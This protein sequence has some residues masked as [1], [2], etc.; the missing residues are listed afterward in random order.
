[1]TTALIDQSQGVEVDLHI[2]QGADW[3]GLAFPILDALNSPVDLSECTALGQIRKTS[4]A[5]E[6]L[7]TWSTTPVGLNQG[8][9]TLS[10]NLVPISVL[11]AH[12]SAWRFTSARYDVFLTNPNADP[13]QQ[14][15][16]VAF[17]LVIVEAQISRP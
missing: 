1:M 9:I 3:P 16:K 15:I 11:G 2:P 10:G 17:G 14:V 4:R 7:F 8:R 6:V 12:S 13:G 5:T